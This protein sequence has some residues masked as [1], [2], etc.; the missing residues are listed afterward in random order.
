MN[1]LRNGLG[2]FVFLSVLGMMG[3]FFLSTDTAPMDEVIERLDIRYLLLCVFV[4][5]TMDWIVAGFRMWMFASAVCPGVSY[6]ACVKNCAVGGFMGAATPSQTGGGVAQTYVLIKE[7]ANAGQAVGILFM[8]FLST[9]IFYSLVSAGLWGL[10][11]GGRL[12]DVEAPA[13]F[14]FAAIL[15]VGLTVLCLLIVVHPQYAQA[16]LR[17]MMIRGHGRKRIAGWAESLAVHIDD[18]ST[19]M[20]I[21]VSRHKL[22]FLLSVPVTVVLFT[23]KY[24]AAYLAALTLGLH[25][26][27][28]ELL[29]AQVF[30][31]IM[32]YFFPTPGGSGGAEVGMAVVM[33]NL[34]APSLLPAYTLLWRTATMYFSVLVGGSIL[35]HYIRKNTVRR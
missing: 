9:L 12:P 26:P 23:N 3:V 17:R 32:L 25:P 4:V 16:V 33:N 20:K 1:S 35:L 21:F 11:T 30:L 29:V 13:P 8:T 27:L 18:G 7:G 10:A 15:F 24:F 5:P 34:V 6:K 14:A 19:T 22:R 2:I 31:H 28:A